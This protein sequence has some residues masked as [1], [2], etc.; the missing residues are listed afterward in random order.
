MGQRALWWKGIKQL[1]M[2]KHPCNP[3][4][5]REAQATSHELQ[6]GWIPAVLSDPVHVVWGAS[7]HVEILHRRR[8][9]LTQELLEDLLPSYTA[10]RRCPTTVQIIKRSLNILLSQVIDAKSQ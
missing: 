3:G 6:R 5:G 2:T 4:V 8:S 10:A 9:V 1:V 7:A